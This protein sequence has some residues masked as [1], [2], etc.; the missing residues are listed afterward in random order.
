MS[1]PNKMNERKRESVG[2]NKRH[3]QANRQ[4][5]NTNK[6]VNRKQQV[7]STDDVITTLYHFRNW[8]V[9]YFPPPMICQ[10][11]I[12]TLKLNY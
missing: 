12:I 3:N 8:L 2:A 9:Y 1:Q 7:T 4:V 5:Y 6:Q 11:V 10:M